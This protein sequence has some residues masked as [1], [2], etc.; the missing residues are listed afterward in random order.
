MKK[1]L[2]ALVFS[3]IAFGAQAQKDGLPSEDIRDL[4][5]N[6]TVSFKDIIAED[7]VNVISFWATWCV[8]CKAEIKNIAKKLDG[9]KKEVPFRYITISIDEARAENM[10]RTFAANQGWTFPHYIDVKADLKR[11]LNFQS[12]PYTLI[13][14][15]GGKIAGSHIGYQEGNEDKVFEEVKELVKK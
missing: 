13:I 5:T 6:Q 11:A 2:S 7:S 12:V 14:G 15:K 9:W 4:A 3:M 10:A 1:L 8:P